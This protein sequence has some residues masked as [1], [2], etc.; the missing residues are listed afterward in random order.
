MAGMNIY[1][2]FKFFLPNWRTASS[3]AT[4]GSSTDFNKFAKGYE[5]RLQLFHELGIALIKRAASTKAG[6]QA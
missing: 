1:S 4:S 6:M 5:Q 2:V 3:G